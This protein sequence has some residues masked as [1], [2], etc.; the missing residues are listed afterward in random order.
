MKMR[1]EFN[2]NNFLA[3]L[4]KANE[5][6]QLCM[7][8]STFLTSVEESAELCFQAVKRGG[9]IIFAGNGGSAADCQHLATEF[10]SRFNFDRAPMAALALTTDTSC[11]TA[12]GNDYGFDQLFAR[13]IYALGKA[14]DVFV[15]ITTSGRSQNILEGIRAASELGLKSVMFTGG[16]TID[17]DVTSMLSQLV[18]VPCY[19]TASIQEIHIM[20]GHY[21]CEVVERRIYG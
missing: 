15:G 16:H 11:L 5:L 4:H 10:V 6:I 14:D 21:I 9:K 2:T 19:S 17:L 12:I 1:E 20:I 18:S 13:Q 3:N 7:A 8:Q